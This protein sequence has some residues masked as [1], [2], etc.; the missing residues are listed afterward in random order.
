MVMQML[1]EVPWKGNIRELEN[2]LE[3][4]V[5]L[6]DGNTISW[7]LFCFQ[8][9]YKPA[10]ETDHATLSLKQVVDDAEKSAIRQALEESAG[11]RT[12]AAKRLGIARRTLYDKMAAYGLD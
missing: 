4:A 5:L 11:N 1:K 8:T 9:P 2:T 10:I 6:A 3:R 7:D 12:L